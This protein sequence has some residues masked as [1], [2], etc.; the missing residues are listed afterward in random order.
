MIYYRGFEIQRK[1]KEWLV[2]PESNSNNNA[3]WFTCLVSAKQWI[4]QYC[5]V[6]SIG[7]Y[8]EKPE[9]SFEIIK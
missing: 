1:S 2:T 7:R 5:L 3:K 8:K 4:D 6:R 9:M